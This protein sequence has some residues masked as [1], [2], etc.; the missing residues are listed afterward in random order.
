M[1]LSDVSIIKKY[2]RN[3]CRKIIQ[4]NSTKL[5]ACSTQAGRAL[6]N[7]SDFEIMPNGIDFKKF[8]YDLSKRNKVRKDL[9]INE[10]IKVI[11]H[12]GRLNEAKN[13]LFLL[14][15]FFEYLKINPNSVLV[16]IGDGEKKKQIV[17]KIKKMGINSKVVLLGSRFDVNNL[18]NS[19]DVVVFPSI[20]EGLPLSLLELQANG[21]QCIVS[22]I[23]S[24]E[25]AITKCI[26]YMSLNDSPKKWAELINDRIVRLETFDVVDHSIYSIN[27]TIKKLK[28]LY[29]CS[30]D[31]E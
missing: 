5:I 8:K 3:I 21:L 18:I 14:D 29:N 23:V 27:E 30:G 12:V 24:K 11:G 20:Y 4:K 9:K 16:L 31:K 13:H 28:L 10:K 25:V 1:G 19:F 17:Q 7:N 26:T 6:F 22:D 2:K 15:V